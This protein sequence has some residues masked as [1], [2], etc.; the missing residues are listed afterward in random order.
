MTVKSICHA[1][2][3]RESLLPWPNF[4][5][6]CRSP[7]HSTGH[8]LRPVSGSSIWWRWSLGSAWPTR[9]LAAGIARVTTPHRIDSMQ[10]ELAL[11]YTEGYLIDIPFCC[12][13]ENR[14]FLW[15]VQSVDTPRWRASVVH[16]LLPAVKEKTVWWSVRQPLRWIYPERNAVGG[17]RNELAS[18]V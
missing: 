7:A 17:P 9:T 18:G 16:Q 3:T 2:N 13:G 1:E 8:S 11:R 14:R 4:F 12:F 10:T 6:R 5:N 15:V